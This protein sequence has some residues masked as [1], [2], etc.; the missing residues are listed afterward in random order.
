MRRANIAVSRV[1]SKGRRLAETAATPEIKN[2]N[3]MLLPTMSSTWL[4]NT[5]AVATIRENSG[6]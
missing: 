4:S 2:M 3:P 1:P 6:G 5:Q